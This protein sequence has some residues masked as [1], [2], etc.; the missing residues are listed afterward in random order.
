[1]QVSCGRATVWAKPT[2]PM[3]PPA[4]RQAIAWLQSEPAFARVGEQS[5]RLAALQQDLRRSQPTMNLTVVA[6]ENGQ[7]V[8]GAAHAALAAKVRQIEPSLV[9]SLSGRGWKV[10]SIRFRTQWRPDVPTR[11]RPEKGSPGSAA[12]ANISALAQQIEHPALSEA[13]RRLASRHGG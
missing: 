10:D 11:P 13:L 5:A 2:V 9:A 4:T 1:M 3:K 6:Y 12:V 8:V 7:L